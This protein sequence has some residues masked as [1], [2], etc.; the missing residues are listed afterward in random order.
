MD[1]NWENRLTQD[2]CALLARQRENESMVDYVTYNFFTNGDYEARMKELNAVAW[3]NPNLRFRDGYGMASEQVIDMDSVSRYEAEITHGPEKRQFYVRNF[4][5]VPDFARGSCAPN[6][7]S[8]LRNGLD[9]TSERQCDPLAEK[10][11]SRFVPLNECM[12]RFLEQGSRAIPEMIPIGVNSRDL[13]RASLSESKR[14]PPKQ[15]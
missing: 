2:S 10:D 9:T 11:F 8:L 12:G 6:T 15:N 3:K 1:F 13:V 4:H 7:E 5:A 14:C